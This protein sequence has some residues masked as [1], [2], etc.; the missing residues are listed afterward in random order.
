MARYNPKHLTRKQQEELW[1]DFCQA[2]LLLKNIDESRR[3]FRDILNRTERTMLARRLQ[4]ALLLELGF[5]YRQ[6]RKL[7]ST[8]MQTISRVS[9]WLN[10]GRNGYRLIIR[11]KRKEGRSDLLK[12]FLKFY[13]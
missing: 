13:K 8:S 10:F 1:D 2:V 3:F 4:I 5:D 9:R 11:R 6:I 7:M 12:K